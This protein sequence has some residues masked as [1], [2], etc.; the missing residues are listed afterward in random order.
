MVVD[1]APARAGTVVQYAIGPGSHVGAPA[2]ILGAGYFSAGSTTLE[3]LTGT[4]SLRLAVQYSDGGWGYTDPFDI[5]LGG[6][7]TPPS[8]PAALPPSFNGMLPP[9]W[10]EPSTYA[11]SV[12]GAGLFA[13]MTRRRK[14]T[15]F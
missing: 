14:I 10:P 15:S 4:V 5:T 6:A 2:T 3:G 1:G 12:L 7:G 13:I 8:P 11:L 9:I